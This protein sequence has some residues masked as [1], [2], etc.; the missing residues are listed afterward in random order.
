MSVKTFIITFFTVLFCLNSYVV[1]GKDIVGEM[2]CV[3]KN[4]NIIIMNDGVSKE[5][6]GFTNSKT[7][8]SLNVGDTF[9]IK[10]N[11]NEYEIS[12]VSQ[13]DSKTLPL[14]MFSNFYPP[15]SKFVKKD[16]STKVTESD[17]RMS[18]VMDISNNH[19]R[20]SGKH[21]DFVIIGGTVLKR[22]YKSDW[23]GIT[24]SL[25]EPNEDI[26]S[27]SISYNCKSITGNTLEDFSEEIKNFV[28]NKK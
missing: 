28:N 27:H 15:S 22:Y 25:L 24:T 13:P 12:I 16:N 18:S 5:Y 9:K 3:V 7:I 6:K 1:L 19:I 10:F 20:L 17:G 11:V 21:K 23:M 14:L 26:E 2:K 8:K 4:Q